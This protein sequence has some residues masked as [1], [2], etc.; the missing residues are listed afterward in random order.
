MES[1]EDIIM[2]EFERCIKVIAA[3]HFQGDMGEKV[4]Y[5]EI[6][7]LEKQFKDK[8]RWINENANHTGIVFDKG[9]TREY[10]REMGER[11][12]KLD[13]QEEEDVSKV[14][15]LL[16]VRDSNKEGP[17]QRDAGEKGQRLFENLLPMKTNE[18]RNMEE[19]DIEDVLTREFR[20]F[21]IPIRTWHDQVSWG[22]KIDYGQIRELQVKFKERLQLINLIA[23]TGVIRFSEHYSKE[24]MKNMEED[25]RNL[26][27]QEPED[28][29]KAYGWYYR[30]MRYPYVDK[31]FRGKAWKD[32]VSEM[33]F[34]PQSRTLI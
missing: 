9:Y 26:D 4:D 29:I 20:D 24:Y 11:L 25:F 8:I 27:L 30:P 33:K 13:L 22:E 14:Y 15:G 28:V 17:V 10:L 32:A 23:D 5:G 12:E 18:G 2:K 1:V 34:W 7:E 3:H 6:R 16:V 21:I 19:E 31:Y